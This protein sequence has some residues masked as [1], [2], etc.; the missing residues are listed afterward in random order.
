MAEALDVDSEDI[1]LV[2][3]SAAAH[4]VVQLKPPGVME[5]E[6]AAWL[7]QRLRQKTSLSEER[8][9]ATKYGIFSTELTFIDGKPRQAATWLE[10][11]TRLAEQVGLSVSCGDLSETYSPKG[12]L[13]GHYLCQEVIS[14]DPS[15]EELVQFQRNQVAFVT[16][17]QFPHAKGEALF[18][19]LRGAVQRHA[20]T[21][22][23][24]LEA[25]YMTCMS[26]V[27]DHDIHFMR[28]NA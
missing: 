9:E 3:S 16:D 26:E 27:L 23:A 12:P 21:T 5:R 17:Y 7:E 19:E 13:L 1:G 15:W 14:L 10:Y 22:L 2:I 20:V 11:P 24:A 8:I 6:S 18:G 25:G 4:D 28:A